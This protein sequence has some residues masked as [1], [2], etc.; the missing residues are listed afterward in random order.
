MAERLSDPPD[1]EA[2]EPA[3]Q[4]DD[5]SDVEEPAG[6]RLLG[7]SSFLRRWMAQV[8]S[9]LGDWIGLFA[10]L[11]LTARIGKGSPEAAIALVMAS[12]EVQMA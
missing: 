11:T 10:I 2:T 9:S 6:P 3:E 5:S 1:G 4:V 12:P 7:S 8:I